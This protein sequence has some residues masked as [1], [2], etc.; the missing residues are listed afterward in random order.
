[1][2]AYLSN[3]IIIKLVLGVIYKI[4]VAYF[5]RLCGTEM[6]NKYVDLQD[7]IWHHAP[8]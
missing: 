3:K 2:M 4:I 6:R 7:N 8:T 1:M 5:C